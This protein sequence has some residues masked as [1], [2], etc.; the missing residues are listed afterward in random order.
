MKPTGEI[1]ELRKV[2]DFI[3][4]PK[5]RRRECLRE[6]YKLLEGVDYLHA[7]SASI[8]PEAP[9]DFVFKWKDDGIRKGKITVK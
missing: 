8:D 2:V 7:V 1:F 3:R 4:I 6:F 9:F 5:A